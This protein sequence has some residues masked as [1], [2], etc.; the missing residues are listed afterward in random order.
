MKNEQERQLNSFWDPL[1]VSAISSE[2]TRKLRFWASLIFA[3]V[4]VSLVLVF[5][6]L[7][8][9]SGER[10]KI[11]KGTSIMVNGK[12]TASKKVIHTDGL[13]E[14]LAIEQIK[15]GPPEDLAS[16]SPLLK[17]AP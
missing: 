14:E 10:L 12:T 15:V 16:Q 6:W 9:P 17:S 2:E 1:Q 11:R 4:L 8:I 13:R 7:I 5:A 3:L